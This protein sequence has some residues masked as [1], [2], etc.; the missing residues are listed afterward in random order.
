KKYPM[1]T[2]VYQK[3]YAQANNF[4]LSTF[5]NSTGFNTSLLTELG[6]FVFLPDIVIS[7]EGPGLSALECVTKGIEA[8]TNE[9]TSIDKTKLGLIGHSFGG[10]ETNFIITQTNLFA[11]A[12]SGAAISDII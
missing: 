11:A 5:Q 4:Y 7:D 1:I 10:Y 12:V 6:Y 8:I 2:H 3:Q 9:E